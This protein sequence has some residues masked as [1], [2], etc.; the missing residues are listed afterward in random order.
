MLTPGDVRTSVFTVR[1][2][3]GGYDVDEVDD[4]LDEVERTIG[5]LAARVLELEKEAGGGDER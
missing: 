4:F 2:L 3:R 1:R 5:L